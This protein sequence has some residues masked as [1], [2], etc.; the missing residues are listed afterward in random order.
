MKKKTYLTPEL[1]LV[2][3]DLR[4]DIC[5]TSEGGSFVVDPDDPKPG[6]EEDPYNA[7]RRSNIIWD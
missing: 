5:T 3:M 1:V 6:D 2:E 7:R 4:N